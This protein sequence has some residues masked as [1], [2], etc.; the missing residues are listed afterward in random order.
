MAITRPLAAHRHARVTF[1]AAR[2]TRDGAE[3]FGFYEYARALV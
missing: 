3:G 1:G 2:F